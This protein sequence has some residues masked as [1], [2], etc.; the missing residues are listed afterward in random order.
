MHLSGRCVNSSR[1]GAMVDPAKL[2]PSVHARLD[3]WQRQDLWKY[4]C[5][6]QLPLLICAGSFSSVLYGFN[7]FVLDIRRQFEHGQNWSLSTGGPVYIGSLAIFVAAVTGSAISGKMAGSPDDLTGRWL[8]ISCTGGT[9]LYS[10]GLLVSSIAMET[11]QV[12]LLYV[13]FSIILAC[14]SAGIFMSL[15][16]STLLNF[17][18]AGCGGLGGG[19]MGFVMGLWPAAFSFVGPRL[20]D[21]LGTPA[22]FQLLAGVSFVLCAPPALLLRLPPKEHSSMKIANPT[23]QLNTSDQARIEA[24]GSTIGTTEQETNDSVDKAMPAAVGKLTR[25]DLLRQR[26]FWLVATG[27]SCIMLPGFGIKLLIS[28]QLYAVYQ[29][30]E[31]AQ[32]TASFVFLVAYAFMRLLT[33][34]FADR[35]GV[36]PLLLVLGT[37]QVVTL[38]VLGVCVINRWPETWVV[39]LD[40]IVGLSLA[41]SKVLMQVWC[42]HLWG[43]ASSGVAFGMV[44]I[45]F[46][47]AAIVGSVSAWWALCQMRMIDGTP[48]QGE[49]PELELSFAVWL[50]ACS[51]LTAVGVICIAAVKASDQQAVAPPRNDAKV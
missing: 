2:L 47:V 17:K 35:C 12:W 13:G 28:P 22:T 25:I 42:M 50:W 51:L 43:A 21:G 36:K 4:C 44:N 14:G 24:V 6:V 15:V 38:A 30:S 18:V 19:L 33:G 34:V 27:V 5:V 3:E 40:A 39:A 29:S 23:A 7:V 45:G 26:K 46:G 32:S 9:F 41:G 1:E 49:Q 8:R 11:S 48:L 10:V 16:M 20:I 31:D 37:L